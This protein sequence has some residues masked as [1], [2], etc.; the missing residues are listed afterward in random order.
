[1][2]GESKRRIVFPYQI[3]DSFSDSLN[4][5]E[6]FPGGDFDL[7]DDWPSHDLL[8]AAKRLTYIDTHSDKS[9][10]NIDALT[11]ALL[12]HGNCSL[13]ANFEWELLAKQLS[14]L[15]IQGFKGKISRKLRM[16]AQ[17]ANYYLRALI[18]FDL[19]I[20]MEIRE[21]KCTPVKFPWDILFIDG[22]EVYIGSGK[23]NNILIQSNILKQK[24]SFRVEM[25]TQLTRVQ[26][27]KIAIG[28]L[29]SCGWYEFSLGEN[30]I[31]Y[32]H[33]CPVIL[34]F[35]RKA[36][37]YILDVRGGIYTKTS[38]KKIIQVDV[39]SAW[40]AR[41]LKDKIFI[42]DLADAK[43]LIQIDITD[44]SV[45]KIDISPVLLMND[46][47]GNPGGFYLIDKM[48]GRIFKYDDSFNFLGSKL[49]FG[50]RYGCISDP[51]SVRVHEDQIY[52]VS[53][54]GNKVTIMDKF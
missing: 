11:L 14:L 17:R 48:Q 30:V 10:Q 41:Y 13:P 33:H 29:Y 12:S 51:I 32:F 28:S 1:M 53:W 38:R 40:R 31:H 20:S 23:E 16:K 36:E 25:P 18:D 26:K 49:G 2:P 37:V 24:K 35:E 45:R 3:T 50:F 42:S 15:Y 52:I 46:L 44:W 22:N 43:N 34:V 21:E 47:C 7:S 4:W 5:Y 19:D 39:H 8:R 6:L 9:E 27:N 54:L